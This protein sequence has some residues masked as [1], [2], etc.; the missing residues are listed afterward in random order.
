MVLVGIAAAKDFFFACF[1]TFWDFLVYFL[2]PEKG[3]W[4]GGGRHSLNPP[5]PHFLRAHVKFNPHRNF[6]SPNPSGN[7][8]RKR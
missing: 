6:G 2:V 5:P 7:A 4:G 8:H 1:S 3:G